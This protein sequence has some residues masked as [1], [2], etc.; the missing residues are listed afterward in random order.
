MK[1][2]QIRSSKK[3]DYDYL[4]SGIIYHKCED[5]TIHKMIKSSWHGKGGRKYYYYKC[6]HCNAWERTDKLDKQIR[7]FLTDVIFY[8]NNI[9]QFIQATYQS[10]NDF[11]EDNNEKEVLENKIKEITKEID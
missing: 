1:V 3:S 11:T 9:E 6:K 10:I 7:E 2:K 8:K 5:G 4:L